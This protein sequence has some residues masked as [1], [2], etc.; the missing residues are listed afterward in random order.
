MVTWSGPWAR[1][2][3]AITPSVSSVSTAA[4]L[5][6]TRASPRSSPA[7]TYAANSY[8]RVHSEP[9]QASGKGTSDKVWSMPYWFM[10]RAALWNTYPT[11]LAGS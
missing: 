9:F 2:C 10:V 11:A 7:A 6:R 3:I 5:R 8:S 4:R 1:T